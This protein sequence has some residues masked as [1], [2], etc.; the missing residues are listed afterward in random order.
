[1]EVWTLSQMTDPAFKEMLRQDVDNITGLVDL[2]F[3]DG[4]I[5]VSKRQAF[6]NLFWWPILTAF[7]IP[8]RKDH[9]IRNAAYSSSVLYTLW[10]KYCDEIMCVG[11]HNEKKLKQVIWNVLQDMYYFGCTDLAAYVASLDIIDM[12][13]ITLD[14]AMADIIETKYKFVDE[15]R[16]LK[17]TY[18]TKDVETIIGNH[19]KEIT[20]LLST[21]GALQNQRLLPFQ[22]TDQLNKHQVPQT[23][24]CFGIRTDINDAIVKYVVLG[25]AMEGLQSIIEYVDESLSA[26]KTAFYNQQAVKDSQYLNRRVQ[27][28][29]SSLQHIYLGD[30]GSTVTT[31]FTVR[32]ASVAKNLVGKYIVDDGRLVYLND[33]NV[34]N[35]I[36]K[37]VNLRSPLGCRYRNGVCEICGGRIYSNLNLK[38]NPGIIAAI[39]GMEPVTQKILSAKHLVKTSSI[40]YHIPDEVVGK[41]FC[42][43]N[44]SEI[45]WSGEMLRKF[46]GKFPDDMY[47]GV[48]YDSFRNFHDVKLIR[49]NNVNETTMSRISKLYIRNKNGIVLET[50]MQ[51]SKKEMPS[52]SI[53][54]LE[55]I[56]KNFNNLESSNGC[57]WIPMAGTERM[58]LM[59]T[60]IMN[61]NMLDFVKRVANFLS[62]DI[63]KFT[64][65]SFALEAFTDLLYGYVDVNIAHLETILRAFQITS[66]ND[67]RIPI[68][69]NPD[70]VAFRGMDRVLEF[71][72]VGS[73][74]AYEKLKEYMMSVRTYMRP[75]QKS[76]FDCL[77]GYTD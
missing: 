74:L 58:S 47:I 1:M 19:G 27:L 66:E 20:T 42:A 76:I 60:K 22:R 18:S 45:G 13:E 9:F 50:N 5:R 10:N 73:K 57:I 11:A 75:K 71:R 72:H 53:K 77:I 59:T 39:H 38:L 30:C 32:S 14:K 46:K 55:H 8:L 49:G 43:K 24:Y 36:G 4:T 28:V 62:K 31:R 33:D 26:R 12:S 40:I 6:L 34:N 63:S 17:P 65:N 16:E 69:E 56:R 7:D 68:V 25:S 51:V 23:L 29:C 61:D 70:K 2:Q 35:Y 54:M 44:T 67:Y 15:N 21:K 52:F 41:V 64:T 48:E 3:S 37:T